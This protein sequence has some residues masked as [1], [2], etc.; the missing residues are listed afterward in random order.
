MI[1]KLLIPND[2]R[3]KYLFFYFFSEQLLI[4]FEIEPLCFLGV[5]MILKL[6]MNKQQNIFCFVFL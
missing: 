1:F 5:I 4:Y 3:E 2:K 6:Q